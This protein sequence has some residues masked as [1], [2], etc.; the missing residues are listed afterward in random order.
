MRR[1]SL[2]DPEFSFDDADIDGFRAGTFR[3]GPA[4]GV[5]QLGGTVYD[6]PPGQALCPY[7]YEIGE[8]EFAL[9]LVGRPTLRVPDGEHELAPLDV[10][11]FPR[12]PQGAHLLRNDTSDPVRVLLVSTIVT[13]TATVYPDS[14][15]IGIWAG[16]DKRDDVI[17]RRSSGVDYYDGETGA[18]GAR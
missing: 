14:D 8:D 3:F 16:G 10:V 4:I 5:E 13:P 2:S 6:L 15:K 17:V 12:G 1:V 9:V 11:G 7:H 18:A